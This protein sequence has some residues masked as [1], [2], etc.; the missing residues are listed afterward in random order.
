V[1]AGVAGVDRLIVV[2]SVG[3]PLAVHLTATAQQR[4]RQTE[5]GKKSHRLAENRRRHRK[6]NPPSKKMDD[7]TTRSPFDW[8][9]VALR[10]KNLVGFCPDLKGRCHFCGRMGVIVSH[11]PRRGYG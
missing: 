1:Y 5:K 10:K 2:M 6:I 3:M 9:M 8:A 11:F 4:Y 7:A